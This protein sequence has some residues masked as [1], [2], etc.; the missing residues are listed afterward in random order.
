MNDLE[1]DLGVT[2]IPKSDQLNADD[3]IA[4]AKTIRIREMK[5]TDSETQPISIYFDGDNNKPYKPSKSMRRV[6]VQLWG[7]NGLEYVGR[8]LTLFRDETVKWA[9]EAVGGIVISHASHIDGVKRV[10]STVAKGKKRLITISPIDYV[11]PA[12]IDPTNAISILNESKTLAELQ[13]NWS[14]LSKQEQQLPTVTAT[15]DKLKTELA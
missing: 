15:K 7:T 6:L 10:S 8:S 14:K 9:G 3:L 4:G 5:Q 1:I 2:I 13:T 12:P 11:A